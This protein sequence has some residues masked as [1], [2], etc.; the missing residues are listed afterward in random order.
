M[1]DDAGVDR[2]GEGGGDLGGVGVEQVDEDAD[3]G[4]VGGVAAGGEVDDAEV[5][6]GLRSHGGGTPVLP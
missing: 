2:E 1:F 5:V 4:G 3:D 6:G